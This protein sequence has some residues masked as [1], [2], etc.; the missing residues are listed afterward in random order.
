MEREVDDKVGIPVGTSSGSTSICGFGKSVH[1]SG[2][3]QQSESHGP[4]YLQS[5]FHF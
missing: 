3:C 2:Y 1:L 4:D 5:T